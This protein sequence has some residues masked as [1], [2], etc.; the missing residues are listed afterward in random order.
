MDRA[1]IDSGM[2]PTETPFPLGSSNDRIALRCSSPNSRPAVCERGLL[3]ERTMVKETKFFRKQADKAERMSR[4]ASDVEL[5][6]QR[7]TLSLSGR[8]GGWLNFRNLTLARHARD[9]VRLSLAHAGRAA[10]CRCRSQSA[11]RSS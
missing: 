8:S 2:L 7:Q 11:A 6:K 5:A 9:V 4:S 1:V 3:Q 10:Q